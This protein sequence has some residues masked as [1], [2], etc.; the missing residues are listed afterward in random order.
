MA[1]S[2]EKLSQQ[3]SNLQDKSVDP[4]LML[5][6]PTANSDSATSVSVSTNPSYT[7]SVQKVFEN[8]VKAVESSV[9]KAVKPLLA[10]CWLTI[11]DFRTA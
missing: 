8:S 3:M 4:L 11:K 7:G 10:K 6:L 9:N 5:G 1:T 2:I